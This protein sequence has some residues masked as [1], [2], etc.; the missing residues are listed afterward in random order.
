MAFNFFLC[1][2]F[3]GRKRPT[4]FVIFPEGTRYSIK[5]KDVL[6]KSQ[7]FAVDNDL[8]PLKHVSN[9]STRLSYRHG[10][11][12]QGE[13][14]CLNKKLSALIVIGPLAPGFGT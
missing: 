14:G 5:R 3:I 11:K 13:S 8:S 9:S 6:E 1:L 2:L 10:H 7:K 4:Y 12:D